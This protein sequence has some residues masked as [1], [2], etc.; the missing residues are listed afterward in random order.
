[1]QH[2]RILLWVQLSGRSLI[3]AFEPAGKPEDLWEKRTEL[4]EKN[5]KG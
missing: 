4:L 2:R 1:M 3:I 5:E